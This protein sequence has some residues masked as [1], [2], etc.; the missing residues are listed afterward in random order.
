MRCIA[1]IILSAILLQAGLDT[2][3]QEY[4]ELT[5]RQTA[6][7]SL[8]PVYSWQK[9]LG[10]R[11]AD[12]VYTVSIEYPEFVDLS[13]AESRRCQALTAGRQLPDWPQ[14]RQSV[15]VSRKQGMLDV[16]FIPIVFREGRYQKIAGCKLNVQ[17]EAKSTAA[18][19]RSRRAPATERYAANSVLSEGTWAKIRTPDGAV[20]QLTEALVRRMGFTSLDKVKIYG[21]GGAIQ[22]ERLT[23]DYLALTDDLSEIPTCTVNDR[24]FFYAN[25][26]VSWS[27]P[28]ATTRTRNPYSDYAYYFVTEGDDAMT[29]TPEEFKALYYPASDDYHALYETDDYAWYHGGRN[30]YDKALF[31]IGTPRTYHLPATG[32]DGQLTVVLTASASFEA[33]VSINGQD[34]GTMSAQLS[35]DEYTK[36]ADR[37]QTFNAEG[38]LTA[39]N[40]ITI[41]QTSGGS[42]RLDYLSLTFSE[43]APWPDLATNTFTT[44]EYMGR[45]AN[46]NHHA[47]GAADM[48]IIIPPSQK[49]RTEAE[50][51]KTLHETADGMSVRIIPAD[52]LYNEFSSG[53]PDA[54]AYRRYMKMLYDRAT[55]EADMPRYL[56]LFG[57]GAWDNRM[58]TSDWS[59]YDPDDFLLCFESDNSF[60]ATR[61]YVSDDYFCLLDDEEEIEHT[62]GGSTTYQGK[63]DVA[64]GR[65]SARTAAEAQTL[66]DKITS[67]AANEHAGS[68]Q[69]TICMMGDDGNNNS[70]MKTADK[71][72]EMIQTNHPAYYINKVYWDAYTRQTSSTGNSYPDVTALIK[73]QM[74]EGALMMNYC[75]H[76]INYGLSHEFV[77]R[78]ADFAEQTSLRLPL[79]LTASC[80]IMPFDGQ[81]ENIGETA[82]MNAKGGAIAFFGTTRTVYANYNEAMNLAFTN[83]VLS[84]TDGQRTTIGEAVRLAKCQLV[85]LGSD[86]TPNK[87]QYTLLGDPALTLAAPTR[88]LIVDEINGIATTSGATV[89]L[90]AGS[91]AT[92]KGHVDGA[93]A[94]N[95]IVTLTAR[96]AE[97]TVVCKLNDPSET[98]A[99]F[100]YQDRTKT[101]Y[102]G[103]DSLRQG[104]FAITFAIPKDISYT[105]GEGLLNLYAIDNA[106]ATEA[107]GWSTNLVLNGSSAET[108]DTS[109]PSIYCYLNTPTFPNGGKTNPT[110]YFVADLY[111]E[112]GINASGSSIGHDLQLVID[113]DMN[114]TYDLNS[115]FNYDFGDYRSGT[116]RYSIP[117]LATGK[118][119][120]LFRAWDVLNNSSTA[121]LDFEVVSDL[122]VNC[123]DVDCTRNPAVSGTTFIV[124]HDRAGCD[125][126]LQLD[127]Y[128]TAGRQLWRYR[129]AGVSTDNTY[130]FDWNLATDGGRML[131]TG[132][133]LFKVS[134]S[135][136]GSRQSSKT[137]KLIIVKN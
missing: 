1:R 26:P 84:Q 31:T 23:G 121:E 123:L 13:K 28:T 64:V 20:C 81:E 80:D 116:V 79:W 46:Q 24:K 129:E 69:N 110:P 126:D 114:K 89:G 12:S 76:G 61:C 33:T 88:Q 132:V 87:L 117:T 77:L 8:L 99:P 74:Q 17:A 66:V 124:T 119:K 85:E 111:D 60:S 135:S 102:H 72:A 127:V 40:T 106:K 42:L 10:P 3:A 91:I 136:G 4:V 32:T 6:I 105:D 73:K 36:A 27:S 131:Q 107:H 67:Y 98:D 58:R 11:Y 115:S 104:Q 2:T 9:N 15:G 37:T 47:D 113:G 51:L 108:T 29:L 92:V 18:Q 16:Q 96:D 95:G 7:D 109:G 25:G 94:F 128:D 125:I 55:T 22:P 120:L 62:Q 53:T 56:L 100:T 137:K 130:T 82:M 68:W 44:P 83:H 19:G 35:L 86:M 21:Y 48:I 52:E 50:R 63:P 14:V 41:T 93:T 97:E 38:L 43:P 134:I 45:I 65:L 70:H 5:A 103:S 39:D 112:S 34:L 54:N 71:V 78:L 59:G 57:D 133:Y 118:H 75:G 122:G 30:L 49:W 90:P 101:I